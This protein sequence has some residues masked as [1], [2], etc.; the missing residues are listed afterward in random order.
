MIWKICREISE[1]KHINS[2]IQFCSFSTNQPLLQP[3]SLNK[4]LAVWLYE[5]SLSLMCGSSKDS[6]ATPVLSYGSCL[7]ICPPW[8]EGITQHWMLPIVRSCEDMLSSPSRQLDFPRS[9]H[10]TKLAATFLKPV[11]PSLQI[12]LQGALGCPHCQAKLLCKA[13]FQIKVL[14][15]HPKLE[16]FDR[17]TNTLNHVV[18]YFDWFGSNVTSRVDH[19]WRKVWIDPELF[20]KYQLSRLMERNPR[21]F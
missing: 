20:Q 11:N 4:H 8:G 13:Y 3:I 12:F 2:I 7:A 14:Y 17:T 21:H 16:G 15:W 1:R 6:F 10:A 19:I 5:P 18:L 9:L